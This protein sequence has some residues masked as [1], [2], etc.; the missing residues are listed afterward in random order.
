M[1]ESIALITGASRGIGKE[2]AA[3]MMENGV[4]VIMPTRSEMDL[5]SDKSIDHYL[6]NIPYPIDIL[7]NNAGINRIELFQDLSDADFFDTLQINLIAPIQITRR[8]VPRMIDKHFGRIVNISSIWSLISKPGR[9]SYSV[10]KNGLNGFTRALAIEVAPFN[11]LVNTV[12]PGF[13]NTDLTRQNN[14]PEDIKAI[15]RNIPI[16]RLVEPEEIARFVVFLCSENNSYITG[17]CLVIDGGFT[18]L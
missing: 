1:K 18:C 5:Q 8:I 7:V 13:V 12:A 14:S 6:K 4:K 2:I 15:C 9:L 11:V 17:Q 10:S 3:L 16:G